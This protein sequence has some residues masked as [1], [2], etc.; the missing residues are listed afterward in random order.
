[1]PITAAIVRN[2]LVATLIAL[3]N[4]TT[5]RRGSAELD[6]A[7]DAMLRRGQQ[8]AM[9]LTIGLTVAAEHI[10]HFQPEAG[11]LCESQKCF[12]GVGF[13]SEIGRGS[14]SSGLEAEQTLLVA[15]RR[16]RAVVAKLRCPSSS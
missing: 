6:R 10:R 16:Y 14:R 5:E 15:I 4:V 1:V 2:A 11:H 7:H 12:G 13:G 8:S 9:M 3:L